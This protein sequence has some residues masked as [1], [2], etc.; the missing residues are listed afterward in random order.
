MK[1]RTITTVLLTALLFASIGS[2]SLAQL[3]GSDDFNDN[4]MNP[5]KWTVIAPLLIETNNRL[6]FTSTG[7]GDEEGVWAWT[8]NSGSYTQDWSATIDAFNSSIPSSD[9]WSHLGLFAINSIDDTDFFGTAL[10]FD[11]ESGRVVIG[12]GEVNGTEYWDLA[13]TDQS[14]TLR[15]TYDAT[16]LKLSSS[17]DAGDRSV[18][19][20]NFNVADWEMDSN[21]TFIIAVAGASENDFFIS[22]GQIYADNFEVV[23]L[24][25]ISNHLEFIILSHTYN[26]GDPMLGGDSTYEFDLNVDTDNTITNIT[27]ITPLNEILTATIDEIDEEMQT[28]RYE[29]DSPTSLVS[30]FGVGSYTIT[31]TYSN[32]IQQSTVFEFPSLASVSM[33]PSFIAPDPLHGAL[34][35]PADPSS[36]NVFITLRWDQIDANVN[37]VD[38]HRH[39]VGLDDWEGLGLFTDLVPF[40]NGPFSTRSVGPLPFTPGTWG[41]ENFNGNAAV[42]TNADG[43]LYVT[44]K[45]TLTE[46][47]FTV[48]EA[49]DDED[50]DGLLN[51]W[52]ARYFD[53]PTNA[54]ASV[55]SDLD[56]HNN[57]QESITGMDPTNAASVFMI[58]NSMPLADDFLIEWPSVSGR[59]YT[60]YWSTNLTN[61]FHSMGG[62]IDYPQNSYTDTVHGA[63]DN[64]FYRVGVQMAE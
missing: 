39:H 11:T 8:A 18:L 60:A 17:F 12:G 5:S 64:C 56:G 45:E 36:S 23:T 22:S 58:T 14:V 7:V 9:Q 53:G 49:T 35:S 6:E 16:A 30:R 3:S 1:T 62:D 48:L 34:F 61:S 40:A 21:D 42:Q 26:F 50:S 46:Y 15:I 24:P 32:G 38:L 10:G 51:W 41:I 29:I 54:I 37:V 25:S 44:L 59:V 47:V 57:L 33:Q 52:E 28:W 2:Q 27:C 55:D 19:L 43:V 4:V 13:A 20:T 31:A 63:E